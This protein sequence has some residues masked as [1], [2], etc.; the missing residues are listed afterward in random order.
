LLRLL[1]F[2]EMHARESKVESAYKATYDWIQSSKEYQEWKSSRDGKLLIKGKAGCGKSTMMRHLIQKEKS[3]E[4]G[5]SGVV[6]GFFFNARGA[7]MEKSLEAM[8]RT[9]LHQLLQQ[10]PILYRRLEPFHSDMKVVMN[11]QVRVVDW[12][13]ETLMQMFEI[14][15]QS[16]GLTGLIYIDALDEGEGFL[17]SFIFQFLESQLLESHEVSLRICLSSRPSN[18]I[19][20]RKWTTIDLGESNSVD[21]KA[22]ALTELSKTA[23]SCPGM[24]YESIVPKIAENILLKAQGVFLWVKLV[25]KELLAAMND[26]EPAGTIYDILSAT[27]ADLWEL[28]LSCLQ[29]VKEDDRLEAI[30]IL[31]IVLVAARPLTIEELM[32]IMAVASVVTPLGSKPDA[33]DAVRTREQMKIRVFNL[34]R[35]LVE[36]AET[37]RNFDI[38]IHLTTEVQFMHQSVKDFLRGDKLPAE[39]KKLGSPSLE[40]SGH[41]LMFNC[42]LHYLL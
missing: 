19:N 17:P 25:V 2:P 7:A 31:Q 16:P 29:K 40:A 12:T 5:N 6:C 8:F 9:L 33:Q 35:G 24:G 11:T 42:C 26:Y 36:V 32:E 23:E 15:V 4:N 18:F 38:G 14:T 3:R 34:C 28:F 37:D 27:P 13:R 22:Y 20:H 10:D 1:S 21:I 41:E 30:R 39:L